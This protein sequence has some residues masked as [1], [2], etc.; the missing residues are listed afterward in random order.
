MRTYRAA[1]VG[2]G[3]RGLAQAVAYVHHPRTALVAF[4]D[5]DDTRLRAA[6]ASYGVDALYRDVEELLDRERPD[7]VAVATRTDFHHPLAVQVLRRGVHVI[8]EKPIATTLAEADEMIATADAHGV[9]LAVHHQERVGPLHRKLQALVRDG[10]I[11][12]PTSVFLRGKGYYGG[13]ELMNI[14][15]H[16]FNAALAILGHPTAVLAH[17]TTDGRETT[18]EDVLMAPGGMGPIAGEDVS[19]YFVFERSTYCFTEYHRAGQAASE[20]ALFEV[21]GTGGALAIMEGQRGLFHYPQFR[22]EPPNAAWREVALTPEER[23]TFG[24]D[25]FAGAANASS[26]WMLDEMVRALDEG[27]EHECSG[28]EARVALEMI[29]GIYASHRASARIR[30]PLAEREHPL[31]A[32]RREAGLAPPPPE[33]VP[34]G[35]WLEKRLAQPVGQR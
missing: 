27:R 33:P 2:A 21:R 6:G 23:R 5:L 17:L 29:M 8:V 13:Y 7:L 30:L 9:R 19:A 3:P 10:A 16:R 15:T 18:P 24:F 14:G 20:N 11:G 25:F 28:R 1:V 26:L 22:F 34:Y 4:C 35:A 32:W 12:E 31:L